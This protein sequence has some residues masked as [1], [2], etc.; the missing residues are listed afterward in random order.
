MVAVPAMKSV[1]VR[2]ALATARPARHAPGIWNSAG[3]APRDRAGGR[4]A[5]ARRPLRA[6]PA[7]AALARCGAPPPSPRSPAGG[8][9]KLPPAARAVHP[10]PERL[11]TGRLTTHSG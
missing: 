11:L 5:T 4:A 10:S 3:R 7:T 1:L 8:P 6:P 2:L 9:D